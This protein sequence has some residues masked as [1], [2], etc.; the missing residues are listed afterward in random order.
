MKTSQHEPCIDI[1]NSLLSGE[2]SAIETYTQA[3]LKFNGE[4]EVSLL[5]LIRKEHI[6]SANQLRQNVKDMGGVPPRDSGGWGMWAKTIE[7]A[8]NFIGT[9]AALKALQEGEEHGEKQ[10]RNAL[11][12]PEILPEFRFMIRTE[13]L[14]RLLR[15]ISMLRW[16]Q[17]AQ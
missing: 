7:G 5:E 16:L 6:E 1:C 3:I 10:Y 15:H 13:L 12:E 17:Q 9:F 4:P 2:I 8:A 11:K 14:P